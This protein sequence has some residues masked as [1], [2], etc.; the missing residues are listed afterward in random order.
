MSLGNQRF[1]DSLT[2]SFE[3]NL[4]CCRQD[5]APML[6]EG[7]A[8]DDADDKMHGDDPLAMSIL[9]PSV[10][11]ALWRIETERVADLLRTQ[12]Q[13]SAASAGAS[14]GGN[15]MRLRQMSAVWVGAEAASTGKDGSSLLQASVLSEQVDC[16]HRDV[17]SD[18]QT[19]VRGESYL[20]N[21][22][23]LRSLGSEYG[24]HKKVTWRCLFVKCM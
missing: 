13:S 15:F 19:I 4:I 9:M 6:D 14:W 8:A 23:R 10:D 24:I 18:H 2:T 17:H 3:S 5:E 7:A 1:C 22:D 12:M 16:V 21:I 11:P 20:N